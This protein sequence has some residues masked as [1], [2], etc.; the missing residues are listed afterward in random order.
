MCAEGARSRV[1]GYSKPVRYARAMNIDD[2]DLEE[3]KK[4]YAA[5]FGEELS[6]EEASEIAWR[7]AD[8]Y[9]F[10]AEPLPSERAALPTQQL[11]GGSSRIPS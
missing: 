2:K 9:T 7:L 1:F 8:L 11:G 4:L 3:F 10:L 6:R 5:E